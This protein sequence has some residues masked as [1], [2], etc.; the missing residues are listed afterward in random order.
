MSKNSDDTLDLGSLPLVAR[1]IDQFDAHDNFLAEYTLKKLHYVSFEDFE[2]WLQT[3][4]RKC[5]VDIE[6]K[7][8]KGAVA[9]FPVLKPSINFFNSEKE[10][11]SPS[12]S[13]GRVAHSL[14][15]LERDLP[16]HVELNP[17]IK[18]MKSSRVRH[19]VFVDDF[20]GTGNRVEK[21][22][23]QM[24]SPTI[25]SW[26]SLGWC[27]VWLLA[28]AGKRKG[29]SRIFGRLK[30]FDP[31]R[32]L[33][34]ITLSKSIFENDKEVR[35]LIK[36]YGDRAFGR[37]GHEGYGGSCTPIVF[38]YGC[39][40]NLPSIFWLRRKNWN[41]VFPN[42]SVPEELYE[43][44]RHDLESD[45]TAEDLW[46]AGRFRQAV[47]F[48]DSN[49]KF[50]GSRISLLILANL[51]KRSTLKEIRALFVVPD[52]DFERAVQEL[53]ETGLLTPQYSLTRFGWDLLARIGKQRKRNVVNGLER[54]YYYPKS[55]LGVPRD[56]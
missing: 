2:S 18:S 13:S 46:L 43:L 28:Y 12:D 44:F 56:V 8:G 9:I 47:N 24:V 35:Y 34:N 48:I 21:F 22:W 41:P 7:Y 14:K 51:S 5:L 30:R 16:S 26:C 19:L 50:T 55:F 15:N 42:R 10:F 11:K 38:Q 17:R 52:E 3:S 31:E 45:L 54:D 39:P 1:W 23:D 27:K 36:K 4:V 6:S 49:Q 33:V 40:N 32:T 20:I 25:K 53:I 29:L 37:S